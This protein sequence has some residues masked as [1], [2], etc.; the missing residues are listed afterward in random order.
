MR[1]RSRII[2]FAVSVACVG[3]LAKCG[4]SSNSNVTVSGVAALGAINAGTVGIYPINPTTGAIATTPAATATTDQN[5]NYS[6]TVPANIGPAVIQV[7][8]GT[9]TDETSGS[10]VTLSSPLSVV[11]PGTS[12]AA[13]GTVTASING[14]TNVA[15]VAF[16]TQQSAGLGS[17]SPNTLITNLDYTVTQA[18][19]VD[20]IGTVPQ[21]TGSQLGNNA[22]GNLTLLNAAFSKAG[23]GASSDGL[24]LSN[25]YGQYLAANG[26][27]TGVNSAPITV[28]N[29]A[30]QSQ[31]ITPPNLT[32]LQSD[33]TSPPA[34]IPVQPGPSS[35]L[36]LN[37]TPPVT[38]PAGTDAP[39]TTSVATS[40][41]TSTSTSAGTNTSQ[42]LGGPGV[43]GQSI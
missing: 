20:P 16:Q 11:L 4:S 5:G 39:G 21:L 19:G 10:Q 13:G 17:T 43:G 30:G 36:T 1:I 35:S 26:N 8:G 25:A 38:A 24:G 34:H 28:R 27:L 41:S 2:G 15:F 29:A 9:Y 7:S 32:T 42:G 12:F 33:I 3:L 14:P 40:T 6:L 37:A 31:S 18:F 23:A 22:A